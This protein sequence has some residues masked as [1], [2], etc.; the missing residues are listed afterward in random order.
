MFDSFRQAAPGRQ[1]AMVGG[2]ALLLCALL[3][4]PFGPHGVPDPNGLDG[5]LTE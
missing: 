2:A 1:M 4:G 3:F 5:R